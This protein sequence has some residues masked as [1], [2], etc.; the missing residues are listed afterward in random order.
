MC[1]VCMIPGIPWHS[2]LT[3]NRNNNSGACSERPREILDEVNVKG[4]KFQC[5]GWRFIG[6]RMNWHQLASEVHRPLH[7]QH[8]HIYMFILRVYRYRDEQL[9]LVHAR[10][11]YASYTRIPLMLILRNVLNITSS[12]TSATCNMHTNTYQV[13]H[14][15][16]IPG[17]IPVLR[18]NTKY[19]YRIPSIFFVRMYDLFIKCVTAVPT[20][21]NTSY[22]YI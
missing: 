17:T 4:F 7:L 13:Q 11:I 8:A 3:I 21:N 12:R 9:S 2:K 5:S 22:S 18:Q 14:D 19:Q 20:H 10:N 1:I 16:N 15:T 6:Q